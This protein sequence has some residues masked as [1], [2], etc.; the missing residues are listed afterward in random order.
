MSSV[1][2]RSGRKKKSRQ[3]AYKGRNVSKLASL[4]EGKN[5]KGDATTD[6]EEHSGDGG[7]GREKK[8]SESKKP[9]QSK[10]DHQRAANSC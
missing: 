5:G 6:E 8:T 7:R 3:S 9:Y 4:S 2:C 10:V 1:Q